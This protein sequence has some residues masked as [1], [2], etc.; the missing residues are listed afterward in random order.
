MVPNNNSLKDQHDHLSLLHLLSKRTDRLNR[1]HKVKM[2]GLDL[3]PTHPNRL[4]T[5][6]K[7]IT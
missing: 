7:P 1:K 4:L 5:Q 3:I 6:A 2:G